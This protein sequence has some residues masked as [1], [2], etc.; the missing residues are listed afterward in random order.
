MP[1]DLQKHC[2]KASCPLFVRGKL[3]S[4]CLR[5]HICEN[6]FLHYLSMHSVNCEGWICHL[7]Y[8]YLKLMK[9]RT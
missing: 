1:E 8:F 3:D 9:G 7:Y 4:R 6:D 5:Q 2:H